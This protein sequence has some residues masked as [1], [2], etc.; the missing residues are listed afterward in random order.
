MDTIQ[1]L[2][3]LLEELAKRIDDM[4][5]LTT[6][7]IGEVSAILEV[8]NSEQNSGSDSKVYPQTSSGDKP[9]VE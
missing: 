6:T 8:L 4:T 2:P 3:D 7:R 1:K 9:P 5:K